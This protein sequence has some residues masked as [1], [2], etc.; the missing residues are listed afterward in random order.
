MKT[1]ANYYALPNITGCFN[2][3][4]TNQNNCYIHFKLVGSIAF[5]CA[6]RRSVDKLKCFLYAHVANIT[7]L[8]SRLY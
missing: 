4:S 7:C 3:L 5:S 8:N 1:C 2:N 6:V